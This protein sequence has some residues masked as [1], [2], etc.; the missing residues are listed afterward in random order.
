[1][2]AMISFLIRCSWSRCVWGMLHVGSTPTGSYMP[3]LRPH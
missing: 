2:L 1:M 3:L